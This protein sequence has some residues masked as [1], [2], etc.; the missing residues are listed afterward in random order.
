MESN[1]WRG[2]RDLATC[3]DSTP[4]RKRTSFRLGS[5][6]HRNMDD[7][8]SRRRSTRDIGGS[9]T[10]SLRKPINDTK[11]EQAIAE[12]RRVYVGNMPYEATIN[13][14]ER[15]FENMADGIEAIN[16][17]VDPM[18]GRNPSYCFID[19]KSKEFA[20]RAMSE[21][22]DR[23]FMRRPLKV[24]PGVKSGTGTGKY[25]IRPTQQRRDIPAAVERW[26]R[27]ENPE[28]QQDA[29]REGRRL[30]IGNLPRFQN[31]TVANKRIRD[32]LSD[33]SVITV[34]KLISPV[35]SVDD[36]S[37]YCFV[38]LSTYSEVDQAIRDWDGVYKFKTCPKPLRVARASGTSKKLGERRRLFFGN[39]PPFPDQLALELAVREFFSG[40]Q[41]ISISKLF[42]P[43]EKNNRSRDQD[44]DNHC[45]CFVEIET[46]EETDKAII[47]LDSKNMW[48]N[49][50]RVK[51]S[52]SIKPDDRYSR[53]WDSPDFL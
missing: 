33:L 6:G 20:C 22:N 50:V 28:D 10:G 13:D 49:R 38:D 23:E 14:V 41:I 40:F 5:Y 16:M 36:T 31:Y 39:L 17:S 3:E 53:A 48:G 2:K 18:T 26:T 9:G 51:P 15:F 19:F 30:Y 47:E 8:K 34:S 12:G 43:R 35:D 45:F 24:K 27:L 1:N 44:G 46:E 4:N 7:H 32:L 25:D 52:T 42:F 11:A 29:T 21:Y 37:C